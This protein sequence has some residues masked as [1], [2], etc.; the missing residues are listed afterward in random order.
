MICQF[1]KNNVCEVASKLAKIEAYTSEPICVKCQ[2][3]AV[4]MTV[5]PTTCS[6]AISQLVRLRA[7]D[8][9]EHAYLLRGIDPKLPQTTKNNP[10]TCLRL[11]FKKLKVYEGDSCG[12]DA[13]VLQMNLWGTEG[14]VER[15]KDIVTH[16][17]SQSITW[18]TIAKV[19]L[20][21][22]LTTES[23]V[24]KAIEDSR[25][26]VLI[27]YETNAPIIN[28]KDVNNAV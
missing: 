13:Y 28:L 12:C 25:K 18:F 10:G 1:N 11:I 6:I 3:S 22:F 24:L 4:P 26:H 17:N 20:G 7:F 15:V 19:A 9:N 27:R 21:G 5:N 14:C 2:S 23:I 16:L 8:S